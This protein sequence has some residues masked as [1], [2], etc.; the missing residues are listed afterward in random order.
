MSNVL[1]IGAGGAGR[2]VTHKCAR[3]PDVFTGITG[4]SRTLARCDE[5]I[6]ARMILTGKWTGTGVF[7]MEQF[8]QD[9]LPW[10]ET[11]FEDHP[12]GN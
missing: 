4:A 8:D 10:E 9:G 7:N 12:M 3:D 2:V 5:M 6:G 1:I 11:T